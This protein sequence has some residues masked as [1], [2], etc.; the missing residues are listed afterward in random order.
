V[1]FRES[2]CPHFSKPHRF[3]FENDSTLYMLYW[4][5][6]TASV[7]ANLTCLN[8]Y[9]N[10]NEAKLVDHKSWKKDDL[11]R[12]CIASPRHKPDVRVLI[13]MNRRHKTTF[14]SYSTY[15]HYRV[16]Q[17]S[18]WSATLFDAKYT[19]VMISRNAANI[20]MVPF[21]FVICVRKKQVD[22]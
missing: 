13:G 12:R 4:E 10:A 19:S 1:L 21:C 22:N 11:W 3:A 15:Q 9:R 20:I 14:S 16:L 7:G 8:M 6:S 2:K 17:R 18:W 5:C